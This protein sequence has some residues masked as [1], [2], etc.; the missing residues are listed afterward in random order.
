MFLLAG[1]FSHARLAFFLQHYNISEILLVLS[2]FPSLTVTC[3]K[4]K[5]PSVISSFPWSRD[6]GGGVMATCQLCTEQKI[7][8]AW[9]VDISYLFMTFRLQ[10]SHQKQTKDGVLTVC[11]SSDEC[12]SVQTVSSFIIL[13]DSKAS[14]CVSK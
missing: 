13:R 2:G 5:E 12:A 9:Q 10:E 6:G 7:Q 3:V 4:Q 1:Q 14:E 8:C 11:V